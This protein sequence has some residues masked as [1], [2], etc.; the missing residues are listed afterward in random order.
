[1]EID[2]IKCEVCGCT[3]IHAC[4]GTLHKAVEQA[5]KDIDGMSEQELQEELVSAGFSEGSSKSFFESLVKEKQYTPDDY[6]RLLYGE[7]KPR[8][9]SLTPKQQRRLERTGE[10]PEGFLE[11]LDQ[12]EEE[13]K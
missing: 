9:P 5:K 13:N 12:W 2:K 1:M 4:S 3:G 8:K 7:W 11:E 10:L 6:K